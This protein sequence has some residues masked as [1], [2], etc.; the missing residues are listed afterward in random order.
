MHVTAEPLGRLVFRTVGI[1]GLSLPVTALCSLAVASIVISETGASGY[2]AITVVSNLFLLIP[3]A[4]L[5]L[6]SVLMSRIAQMDS[7]S[8]VNRAM[9]SIAAVLRVLLVSAGVV[10]AVALAGVYLFHWSDV[11]AVTVLNPQ[12]M[13]AATALALITFAASIPLSVGQ[14]VLIGL[15]KNDVSTAVLALNSVIALAYTF[16]ISATS[17]PPALFVIAQPL[18]LLVTSVVLTWLAL[19]WVR[20][21]L[22]F[23]TKRPTARLH[24]WAAGIPM[25][26]TTTAVTIAIQSARIVLSHQSTVDEVAEYSLLMQ[27]YFPLWSLFSVAGF[28]LWPRFARSRAAGA[29]VWPAL[30]SATVVFAAIGVAC[31]VGML[32]LAAPLGRIVSGNLIELPFAVVAA[33]GL[34]LIIQAAQLPTGMALTSRRG[35]RF[36]AVCAGLMMVSALTTSW[37]LTPAFGSAAPLFTLCSSVLVFQVIPGLLFA[38]FGR[39]RDEVD[40]L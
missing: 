18:G 34:A 8:G 33:G 1:R 23:L 37:M 27:F 19:R 22:R 29:D 11:L 28:V 40:A 35:L 16:A 12:Q 24:L 32:L 21:D 10:S 4:D 15:N 20:F 31:A 9:E 26:L 30:R 3:F 7:S 17:A 36:Q 13:D 5:G 14:R 39:Y 25:L 2:G 6:G 38:R